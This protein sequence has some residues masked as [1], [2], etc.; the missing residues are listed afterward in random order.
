MHVVKIAWLE[1]GGA[2]GGNESLESVSGNSWNEGEG[3][4]LILILVR[5]NLVYCFKRRG[6]V[7]GFVPFVNCGDDGGDDNSKKNEGLVEVVMKKTVDTK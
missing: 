3:E 2:K 7:L 4:A 1:G 5:F 6:G